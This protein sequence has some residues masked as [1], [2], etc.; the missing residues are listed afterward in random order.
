MEKA[1]Y[2]KAARA[3]F[4]QSKKQRG[5][6]AFLFQGSLFCTLAFIRNV[7][8]NHKGKLFE[9]ES[10][11]G[12]QAR[13]P[14]TGAK[15]GQHVLNS[16]VWF[17]VLTFPIWVY[18]FGALT[19]QAPLEVCLILI[20]FAYYAILVLAPY[21][22]VPWVPVLVFLVIREFRKRWALRRSIRSEKKRTV[23]EHSSTVHL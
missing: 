11:H 13:E 22:G 16:V 15:H 18:W 12:S 3:V 17:V 21:V 23:P 4:M 2:F 5:M 19:E 8:G 6:S 1:V 14:S 7:T 20:P 9:K 10:K